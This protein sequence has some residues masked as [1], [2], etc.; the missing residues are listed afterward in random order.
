MSAHI[1]IWRCAKKAFGRALGQFDFLVG[2][3]SA[4]V[5]VIAKFDAMTGEFFQAIAADIIVWTLAGVMAV[6]IAVSPYLV[7]R[8]DQLALKAVKAE[9][10]DARRKR[11]IADTL[12]GFLHE[13]QEMFNRSKTV[14]NVTEQTAEEFLNRLQNYIRAELGEAQRAYVVSAIGIQVPASREAQ[15]FRVLAGYYVASQRLRELIARL[16]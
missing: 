15:N 6:R 7:W 13:A 5:T 2:L 12:G 10:A 16:T 8:D 11:E 1:F 4:A 3:A 9:M 14:G